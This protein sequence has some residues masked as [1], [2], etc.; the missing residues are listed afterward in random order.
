MSARKILMLGDIGVGKTSIAR[1][2]V[3]DRYEAGYKA[4]L[5]LDIYAYTVSDAGPNHD[6]RFDLSIWDTDGNVSEH[7]YRER[8]IVI[9]ASA[10]M[11]VGDVTRPG[12]LDMM[13]RLAQMCAEKLSGRHV[14]F[15]LNK[16]DLLDGGK[17][18]EIPS[19][20]QIAGPPV[21]L[22][23]AK[24]GHQVQTAFRDAATS[25]LRRGY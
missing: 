20:L 6:E 2:L 23:S 15:I 3:F 7:I 11:I 21:I 9:G 4:T 22:T 25:I 24:T 13:V 1:R 8:H 10:A 5:G 17:P 18:F 16:T 14:G 19:A 12:T